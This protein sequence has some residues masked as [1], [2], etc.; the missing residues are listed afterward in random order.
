MTAPPVSPANSIVP[1]VNV[2]ALFDFFIILKRPILSDRELGTLVD[3]FGA[4][5]E[6]PPDGRHNHALKN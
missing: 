3:S 5:A 1:L 4:F 2:S 6:E